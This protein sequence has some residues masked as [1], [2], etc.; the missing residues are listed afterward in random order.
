MVF[1][2]V[3]ECL[4]PFITADLVN[5]IKAGADLKK[6]ALQGLLLFVMA[7]LSL[8]FGAVAGN[9]SAKA[10]A[11]FAKNLRRDLYYKVSEFSF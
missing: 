6:L 5:S 3:M 7:C 8:T 4:I 10:S 2:V 9:T 11:G 1:E